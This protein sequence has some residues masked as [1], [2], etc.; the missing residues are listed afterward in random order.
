MFKKRERKKGKKYLIFD[1]NFVENTTHRAN[2]FYIFHM[3][4]PGFSNRRFRTK[5]R[6]SI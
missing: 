5:G 4:M 1:G 2:L 3:G 6:L